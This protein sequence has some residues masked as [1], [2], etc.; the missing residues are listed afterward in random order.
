MSP[1]SFQAIQMA[2][3]IYRRRGATEYRKRQYK[4]L[5]NALKDI[6]EHEPNLHGNI[7]RIGRKQL[8]GYW[9][10]HE[11]LSQ[12]VRVEHYRVI[13]ELFE[14]LEIRVTVPKPKLAQVTL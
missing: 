14:H 4:R 1:E 9:R 10:R 6:F 8:I 2:M 3:H 5:L 13:Y 11:H 7:N 12:K